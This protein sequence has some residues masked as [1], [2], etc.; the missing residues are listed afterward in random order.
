MLPIPAAIKRHATLVPDSGEWIDKVFW[1]TQ[2]YVDNATVTLDFFQAL[3]ATIEA[4]NLDQPGMVGG[5]RLFVIRQIGVFFRTGNVYD[6]GQLTRNGVLR[7]FIGNKDYSE[8]V[9][10]KLPVAGGSYPLHATTNAATTHLGNNGIQDPRAG[11][12]LTRALLIGP[13][14]NFRVRC[15]WP[16]AQNITANVDVKVLLKGELGRFIQ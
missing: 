3:P 1:D 12:S 8:W 4:G 15:E 16:V 10:S 5:N 7:L 11:Y 13:Q 6:I 2:T 14:L 9:I